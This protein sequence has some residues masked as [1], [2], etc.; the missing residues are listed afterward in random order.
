MANHTELLANRVHQPCLVCNTV[1]TYATIGTLSSR[2]YWGDKVGYWGDTLAFYLLD[3]LR[4][5]DRDST[6]RPTRLASNRQARVF[7]A[8]L[9][10]A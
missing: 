10:R 9:R 2:Q 7:T 4:T 1:R 8:R 5:R 3:A 6:G